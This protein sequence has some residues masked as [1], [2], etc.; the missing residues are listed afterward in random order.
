MVNYYYLVAGEITIN[1]NSSKNLIDK[2]PTKVFK[3][4][5]IQS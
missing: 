2:F 1:L 3:L 5:T 4:I